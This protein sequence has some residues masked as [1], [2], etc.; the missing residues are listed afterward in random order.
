MKALR[1][2]QVERP[3]QAANRSGPISLLV[4]RL[5]RTHYRLCEWT[6]TK[7]EINNGEERERKRTVLNCFENQKAQWFKTLLENSI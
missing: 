4:R 7:Q 1:W 6:S 5:A 2:C 3:D